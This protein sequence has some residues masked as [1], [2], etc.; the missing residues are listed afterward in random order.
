MGY[1]YVMHFYCTVTNYRTKKVLKNTFVFI[2]KSNKHALRS[3]NIG[4]ARFCHD[5]HSNLVK[6]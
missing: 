4:G 5:I 3:Y 2:L 1:A 6:L